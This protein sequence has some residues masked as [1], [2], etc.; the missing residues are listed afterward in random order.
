ML[1]LTIKTHAVKIA[2]LKAADC[3]PLIIIML[4]IHSPIS[5]ERR[6]DERQAF[7]NRLSLKHNNGPDVTTG[8]EKRLAIDH[9]KRVSID[10]STDQQSLDAESRPPAM[11]ERRSK[12]NTC[13]TSRAARIN[14]TTGHFYLTRG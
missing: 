12:A 7:I 6:K 4:E 9:L 5:L 2:E 10:S 13:A 8:Q 14:S 3:C 11:D 1:S